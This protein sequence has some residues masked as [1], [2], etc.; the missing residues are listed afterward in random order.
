MALLLD[1]LPSR[2]CVVIATR[3]DPPMPLGRLRA[4]GRLIEVRA[5]DLRFTAEETA[6]YIERV[7]EA[8][9][10][11][12]D[13][14]VLAGR[15]EGWAAALQLAALSM[16][17]RGDVSSFIAEFAGDDRYIV[18]YLAEEVLDRQ[19]DDVRRF[20]LDTSILDRM[21]GPLC[22]AVTGQ[23]A[24][25]AT[26]EQL[27]RANM[28]LVPLD[29]RRQWY[30]YHH[31]FAD[32]LRSHLA[33]SGAD[34]S[35]LHRRAS[36]WFAA[37]DQV[38]EAIRHALAAGDTT[39]ACRPVRVGVARLAAGS[40][41]IDD[42][43]V[44]GTPPRRDRARSTGARHQPDRGARRDRR[45]RRRHLRATRRCGAI[46]RARSVG[47]PGR[48]CSRDR[49][50]SGAV[51]VGAARRADVPRRVGAHGWRSRRS[52][53]ARG[54]GARARA[55]GSLRRA[56]RRGRAGRPARRGPEATCPALPT[57]TRP[58]STGS[59]GPDTSPTC[60]AA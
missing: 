60:W 44:G 36:D 14:V 41:G 52:T 33:D 42:P 16:R 17:G 29:D 8:P 7:A 10:S 6:S 34:Q 31:L 32:V 40:P 12:D 37:N 54:E 26:L 1:R 23:S 11:A 55:R 56:R 20:L 25:K 51:A 50:R 46:A 27:E 45:V 43:Y 57:G 2:V 59:G 24:G 9:L 49:G 53:I 4:G 21:N 18:D 39:R 35:V 30:R 5:S 28:F 22:D 19:P 38:E 48:A 15:T 47:R 58:A 3:V 13:V